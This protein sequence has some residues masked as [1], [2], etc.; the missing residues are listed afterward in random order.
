MAHELV[1][2]V[3]ELVETPTW[4]PWLR[5]SLEEMQAYTSV[6]P[7]GQIVHIGDDTRPAGALTSLRMR[8]DGDPTALGTWDALSGHDTSVA[9]AH[10]PAGNTLLMLSVS[11]RPDG[12]GR[13][14][15]A[16][17]V[18]HA[19]RVAHDLGLEHVISPF[20][21]S[22]FGAHK[23][24]GGHADFDAY[25]RATRADG[26]PVDPWLRALTR[27]GMEQLRVVDAAMVVRCPLAEVEGWRASYRAGSWFALDEDR[28][29]VLVDALPDDIVDTVDEVWEC[30]ETGS[31]FVDRM[32]GEATYVESNVWGEIPLAVPDGA[33]AAVEDTSRLA[34]DPIV[35]DLRDPVDTRALVAEVAA[36]AP[37]E[38][39][40]AAWVPSSHPMADVV[41][42]LERRVFPDI[43]AFMTAEV[44]ARS[45]FLAVADLSGTGQIVHAFRVTSPRYGPPPDTAVTSGIPMVDEVIE[46]NPG[47]SL[48]RVRAHYADREVD[49]A[50]CIAVETNFRI[51]RGASPSGLRWSDVGYIAIFLEVMRGSAERGRRGVFAHLNSSAVHSLTAVG[52]EPEPF[53]GDPSLH[54]PASAEGEV[55][56]SYA[57]SFIPDTEVN[58]SV[59]EALA[60][61][62]G[63]I[64]DLGVVDLRDGA[65]ATSD[66]PGD[67]AVDQRELHRVHAGGEEREAPDEPDAVA[68]LPEDQR[69]Q[70]PTDQQ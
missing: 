53:A 4:A 62:G 65:A 63:A 43:D 42:A 18:D 30:G 41:R 33:P 27:L 38:P 60:P 14:V 3:H 16:G 55:D 5:F 6:F 69:G 37:D 66:R 19:R 12:Q 26:L 13:G 61:L 17:L 59:F 22:G 23:A 56:D 25:R 34:R 15:S 67:E 35:I 29:A 11:I 64:V 68:G 48:D 54:S 47:T 57:P 52:V 49:L 50:R 24:A 36:R 51:E 58:V 20:R 7:Q 44:E 32:A 39:V 2:H 70:D 8:W 21:P 45:R 1:R 9:E 28:A 31:W 40:A 46:V 10:D